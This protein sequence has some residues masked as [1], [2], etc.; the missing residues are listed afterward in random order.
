MSDMSADNDTADTTNESEE[1]DIFWDSLYNEIDS[2]KRPSEISILEASSDE[3][4]NITD[5]EQNDDNDNNCDNH[6]QNLSH[7]MKSSVSTIDGVDDKENRDIVDE[8]L[9][10][11]KLQ[12]KK[13]IIRNILGE[14]S[15][16]Y[17][18]GILLAIRRRH[19]GDYKNLFTTTY[20]R[21]IEQEYQTCRKH[22]IDVLSKIGDHDNIATFLVFDELVFDGRYKKRI[23]DEV[24]ITRFSDLICAIAYLHERSLKLSDFD[25]AVIFDDNTKVLPHQLG[26]KAYAPPQRFYTTTKPQCADIWSCG[27][28]LYLLLAYKLPWIAAYREDPCYDKWY[29]YISKKRI[30]Q[31]NYICP[32]KFP[33]ELLEYLLDPNED[34]R[35]TISDIVDI[36][37][38]RN[39]IS[40][41]S[42]VVYENQQSNEFIEKDDNIIKSLQ[43]L[44]LSEKL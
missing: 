42:F 36:S 14:V 41:K 6:D 20:R 26:T 22:V 29:K 13:W 18:D 7:C 8:T 35:I 37:W 28:I 3:Y 19:F 31:S 23:P 21:E 39:K 4:K 12:G 40:C 15:Q 30:D 43:D 16:A 10:P 5:S 25:C 9:L 32:M 1:S 38:L 11:E 44:K 24:I 34:T 27:I 2:L 33:K 17:A